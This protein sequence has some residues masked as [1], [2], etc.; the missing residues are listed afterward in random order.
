MLRVVGTNVKRIRESKNLSQGEL[1]HIAGLQRSYIGDVE[2]GHRNLTL[3]SLGLIATALEIHPGILLFENA[4]PQRS[5][6]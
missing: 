1:A 2:R 4:F 3:E 5:Q 6:I